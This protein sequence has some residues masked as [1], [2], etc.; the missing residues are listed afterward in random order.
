M[1]LDW[2]TRS[3]TPTG[4]E[5]K[6]EPCL[7]SYLLV[8]HGNTVILTKLHIVLDNVPLLFTETFPLSSSLR[9]GVD[10]DDSTVRYRLRSTAKHRP[11]TVAIL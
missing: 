8:T 11:A 2:V 6:C 1:T 9:S 4:V 5:P 10:S 7:P 3:R